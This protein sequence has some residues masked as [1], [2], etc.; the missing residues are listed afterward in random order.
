VGVTDPI[1]ED[2]DGT[3]RWALVGGSL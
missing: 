1:D 2:G 3:M